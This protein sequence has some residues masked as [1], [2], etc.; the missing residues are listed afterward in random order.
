MTGYIEAEY[1]REE[2]IQKTKDN[3]TWVHFGYG[4]IFRAFH[5]RCAQKLLNSGYTDRGIIAVEG[6]DEE[7]VTKVSRPKNDVSVVVTFMGDGTLQKEIV[8]SVAESLTFDDR[9]ELLTIFR[10]DSLQ[11]VSFTITEKGY[12][13]T[14]NPDSYMGKVTKLLYERYIAGKGKIAMVSMDNCSKNG[15]KLKSAIKSY[16][17]A[18]NDEGFLKYVEETA[19]PHTM[20][21]KITPRP[22]EEVF[23]MLEK[24]GLCNMTPIVTDKHTYI[25][26]FVNGEEC[27]YLVIEDNFPAGHPPLERCGVIF[28][29]KEQ[30]AKAERLKVTAAL[31]PL[32][33]ALAVYGCVLGYE[34]ISEEMKD[35]DLV[36][37]VEGI[38]KEGLGVVEK[39]DVLDSGQFVRDV[40]EKRLPNPNL[41]D[42]P[43]RI[44][45][46]TSQKVGI[47]F[48]ETIKAYGDNAKS[49]RFI[50]VAIAGWLRYLDAV[51]DNGE[52]FELSPDPMM[53][54]LKS[55]DKS[56]LLRRAD[57]FGID[58]YEVNLA[59]KILSI[60][61][62]MNGTNGSV[63]KTLHGCME[64]YK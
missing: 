55:T 34:K 54:E 16:A 15:D 3:P 5:A 4:N 10:K 44:A 35:C 63:R 23:K 58:L 43:Q 28:T 27:E 64:E 48:G 29:D 30:V 13:V 22:S 42:T 21:D 8:E 37:L 26:P 19:F 40:L 24:D 12:T 49:L 7:I 60:Y 33:T 47:R 39:P 38:A 14:Q 20:I 51:G 2:M 11:M 53:D 31:N 62:A 50:P 52:A 36:K 56:K 32:H 41:P 9:E 1:D 61:S 17:K 6:Y 25:A 59:D 45:T 46:D 57:I 18:F